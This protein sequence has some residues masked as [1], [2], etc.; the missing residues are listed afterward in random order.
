MACSCIDCTDITLP[1]GLTGATGA[2]GAAGAN[3]ADGVDG[4]SILYNSTTEV[5]SSGTSLYTFD[6]YTL[7]GATLLLGDMIHIKAR[8]TASTL[9]YLKTVFVY[10]DGA[11]IAS[12]FINPL[13]G[14]GESMSEIDVY[15]TRTDTTYGKYHATVC[16]G[17]PVVIPGYIWDYSTT[18]AGYKSSLEPITVA[19]WTSNR[20]IAIKGAAALGGTLKCVLFQVTH[21]KKV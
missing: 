11:S 15:L 17:N 2:T 18:R 6:T 8:W 10:F 16:N 20:D 4:V 5:T 13:G 14:Y 7:P 3:G 21:Y 1:T 12:W 19:N 9:D